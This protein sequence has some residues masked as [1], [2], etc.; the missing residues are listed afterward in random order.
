VQ[1][2]ELG[3]AGRSRMKKDE[4]AVAVARERRRLAPTRAAASRAQ[5]AEVNT[6]PSERL[7]TIAVLLRR[8]SGNSR[9]D[10]WGVVMVAALRRLFWTERI[11]LPLAVVVL[12]GVLGAAMPLLIEGGAAQG[13]AGMDIVGPI[14]A[15]QASSDVGR[16]DQEWAIAGRLTRGRSAQPPQKSSLHA[17]GV[18]SPNG[19]RSAAVVAT[20]EEGLN[21]FDQPSEAQARSSEEGAS[22]PATSPALDASAGVKLGPEEPAPEPSAGV[23]LD[24]EQPTP[25]PPAAGP[26]PGSPVDEEAEEDEQVGGKVTLCHKA[27]SKKPKTIVVG[28]AVDEHLTHGDTIGVCP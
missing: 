2:R 22:E 13:E 20:Q 19:I 7:A 12:A 14:P 17:S 4:L 24:D 23:E 27:G 1:A 3:I 16:F 11:A 15:S 5:F 21:A 18:A 10:G 25:E 26:A 28:D 8:L 6:V 9:T